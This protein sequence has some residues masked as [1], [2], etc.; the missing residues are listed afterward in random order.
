MAML[1]C[2]LHPQEAPQHLDLSIDRVQYVEV[3]NFWNRYFKEFMFRE[4]RTGSMFMSITV[5]IQDG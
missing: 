3:S 2:G 5:R 4:T 1:G